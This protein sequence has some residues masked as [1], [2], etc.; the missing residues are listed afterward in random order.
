VPSGY[1]GLEA[2]GYWIEFKNI[3]LKETK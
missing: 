2:E 1:F 3:K